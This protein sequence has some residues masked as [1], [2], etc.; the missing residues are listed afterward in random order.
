MSSYLRQFVATQDSFKNRVLILALQ[1]AH[2]IMN[3]P[4]EEEEN[5]DLARLKL[6]ATEL[7]NQPVTF[8][9]RLALSVASLLYDSDVDL[10]VSDDV[11]IPVVADVFDALSG[12]TSQRS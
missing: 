11:L 6:K 5:L 10:N 9:E 4:Q 3:T 7:I 2:A 12:V 8:S 1:H